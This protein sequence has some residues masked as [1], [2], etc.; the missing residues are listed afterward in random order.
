MIAMIGDAE[1]VLH[2]DLPLFL[3]GF[4]ARALTCVSPPAPVMAATREQV[5]TRV[6]RGEGKGAAA[7]GKQ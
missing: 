4:L 2:A 1:K 3:R 6:V 5:R 7:I